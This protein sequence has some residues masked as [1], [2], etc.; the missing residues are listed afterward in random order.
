CT[1]TCSGLSPNCSNGTVTVTVSGASCTAA[2]ARIWL[3]YSPVFNHNGSGCSTGGCTAAQVQGI[4]TATSGTILSPFVTANSVFILPTPVI[5]TSFT[6]K[7]TGPKD[8]TL[9]WVTATESQTA[10]FNVFRSAHNANNWVQVN[11]AMIPA[12][13]Q[14]GGGASYQF[15]DHVK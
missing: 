9:N 3:S 10:G 14:A 11:A 6:G 1:G 5:F 15:V 12:Q 8:V 4:D 2:G 7:Y 13:G